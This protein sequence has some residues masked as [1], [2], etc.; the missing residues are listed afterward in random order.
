[1]DEIGA[2]AK[3]DK[4]LAAK[5]KMCTPVHGLSAFSAIDQT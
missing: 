2:Q 3:L 4:D 5:M 1:L